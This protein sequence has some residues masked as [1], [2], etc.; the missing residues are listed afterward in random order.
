MIALNSRSAGQS[1]DRKHF[2]DPC[3]LMCRVS[4]ERRLSRQGVA[5]SCSITSGCL[6]VVGLC[7][8]TAC[9]Q[10]VRSHHTLFHLNKFAFQHQASPCYLA[11]GT[12]CVQ[13][14]LY[15]SSLFL[16]LTIDH[17]FASK[18]RSLH[19][20][21][22]ERVYCLH[23]PRSLTAVTVYHRWWAE[24][25]ADT[26]CDWSPAA[27]STSGAAATPPYSAARPHQ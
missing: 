15:F 12:A 25:C 2:G 10:M 24:V 9:T 4:C 23:A 19:V 6:L 11:T 3:Q 21:V 22:F 18:G 13:H 16:S 8:R 14:S 1:T 26:K 7:L 27:S 20:A 5:M 17:V